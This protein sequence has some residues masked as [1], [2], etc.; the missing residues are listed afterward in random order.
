MFERYGNNAII[1]KAKRAV[2][3]NHLTDKENQ[4]FFD[5]NTTYNLHPVIEENGILKVL[6]KSGKEI[7]KF[8]DKDSLIELV[9]RLV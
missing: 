1:F 2:E 4:V 3:G 5:V 8:E 6:S 7:G 9:S